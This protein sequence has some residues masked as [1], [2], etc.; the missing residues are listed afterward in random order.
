MQKRKA[1]KNQYFVKA[2]FE[3]IRIITYAHIC[4]LHYDPFIWLKS[5]LH[6][7]LTDCSHMLTTKVEEA[8]QIQSRVWYAI[9]RMRMRHN[10]KEIH[11]LDE[12]NFAR[13][14][15]TDTRQVESGTIKDSHTHTQKVRVCVHK[16]PLPIAF[17]MG[18]A[19]FSTFATLHCHTQRL[20]YVSQ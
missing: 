11:P 16:Q 9:K 10:P 7:L 3:I 15:H 5:T 1:D 14:T 12:R 13:C 18:L 2:Y 20:A 6:G 17:T 19:P 4:T 8:Y